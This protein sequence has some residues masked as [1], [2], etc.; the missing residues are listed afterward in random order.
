MA[1]DRELEAAIASGEVPGAV[2][3]VTDSAD[4]RY[5]RAF[6]HADA[7]AAA[8]M[9]EDTVFQIA[10]MTKAIT[11]AAA[12]QLVERGRL[13]LDAP[14]GDILPELAAP[15]VLTGF[16]DDN[17]PLT[18]P[19]TR[20]IT[21]R[22]LLTH[23]S[24][25]GYSFMRA[26]LMY[27]AGASTAA[28]GSRASYDLPLL[29]DPGERWEYGVST[30]WAGMAIE[31]V[32][33]MKLG[34]Y[35]AAEITGPLGMAATRFRGAAELPADAAKIHA[36]LPGGG[37]AHVPMVLGG[38]EVQSGGGGLSSTAP[39]YARFLRMILRG[40]EL[41]GVR[42]LSPE[43]I[44]LMQANDLAPGIRAGLMT[45]AFPEMTPEFDPL[46]DQQSGWSLGGFLVNPEPG[47]A[48]RSPGSLHWAGIFNCYYWIDPARDRAGLI[49][50]QVAPFADP[51]VL[52]AFAALERMGC[53]M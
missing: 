10:S 50:A 39:D 28:P 7:L 34:D 26:E 2:A 37:F 53:A 47:P 21:L 6:G 29:F 1:D 19:A 30:D 3:L 11:S 46:P 18:R 43:T 51:G 40:G 44:T 23:T 13:T 17:R 20:P 32:T 12:L 14:M 9:R 27:V 15:R 16:D 31:A 45:T 35:L 33:G 8:P 49:L 38:G 5:L 25:L 4:T 22:H 36:R 48:G 24:G 41:D 52:G 42:V